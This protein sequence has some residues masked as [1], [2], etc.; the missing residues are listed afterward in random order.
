MGEEAVVRNSRDMVDGGKERIVEDFGLDWVM[1]D[2]GKN[3]VVF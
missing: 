2:I 1:E 3:G